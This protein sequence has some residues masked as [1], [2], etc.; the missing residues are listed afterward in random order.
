MEFSPIG[1][2]GKPQPF[3]CRFSQNSRFHPWLGN[4]FLNSRKIVI[5]N[6][7]VHINQSL[8]NWLKTLQYYPIAMK[9]FRPDLKNL[10]LTQEF[11]LKMRSLLTDSLRFFK[12]SMGKKLEFGIKIL[13]QMSFIVRSLRAKP[14]SF[15][16]KPLLILQILA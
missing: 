8:K 3:F 12:K 1:E 2:A 15:E 7:T 10:R 13:F 4:F 9:I 11:P 14:C 6:S 5:L 16:R